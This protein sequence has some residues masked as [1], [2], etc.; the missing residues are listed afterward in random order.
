[1]EDPD[2]SAHEESEMKLNIL[3][4]D[5]N[6]ELRGMIRNQLEEWEYGVHEASDGLEAL[7]KLMQLAGTNDRPN[8]VLVDWHMPGLDGIKL[9]RWI[10]SSSLCA[11]SYG[12]RGKRI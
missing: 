3:L 2:G 11:L 5:D 4:V 7:E 8:I 6:Q 10:K 1:L 12:K 9:C